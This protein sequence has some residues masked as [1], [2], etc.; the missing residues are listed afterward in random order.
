MVRFRVLK[1]SHLLL[2]VS[3]VILL[4]VLIFIGFQ[5][6]S[7]SKD[8]A[9]SSTLVQTSETTTLSAGAEVDLASVPA[10]SI[11]GEKHF[12]I[13]IIP[14]A[15][16]PETQ[17]DKL[18]ILIYHTHSHEA[19]AQTEADP[20]VA[21][22]TWRTTDQTHSVIQVGSTLAAELEKLGAEVVHD[23]TDHELDDINQAYT[24][25]LETLES[26]SEEFDLYIDLHRDAYSEGLKNCIV[27]DDGNEYAQLMLLVGRGDAYTGDA[28]PDYDVNLQFAQSLTRNLNEQMSD[29]CRNVTIKKGRYNQHIA[30]PA[31]LLEV[32]HNMNTLQQALNSMP[33][34]A[35]AICNCLNTSD[36]Q[37]R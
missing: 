37:Y 18:R 4:A 28:K 32:G 9:A 22:E 35:K 14:D 2:A 34:V 15:N 36:F 17:Q 7:G 33:Y 8:E 12:S 24:R 21:I 6:Q 27:D 16:Q 5:S 11:S 29:L 25:S 23:M 20:Y 3:V 13:T 26:Y 19:Y 10:S 31:I 30:S 1:A